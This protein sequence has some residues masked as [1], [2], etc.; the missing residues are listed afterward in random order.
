MTVKFDGVNVYWGVKEVEGERVPVINAFYLKGRF[1]NDEG[2]RSAYGLP[3]W[4]KGTKRTHRYADALQRLIADHKM[5]RVKASKGP[6]YQYI[7]PAYEHCTACGELCKALSD[8]GQCE[9]CEALPF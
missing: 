3:V 9:S 8:S 4:T 1:A 7:V 5:R 6:Y 2:L